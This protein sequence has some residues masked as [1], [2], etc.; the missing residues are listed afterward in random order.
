MRFCD[1]FIAYKIGLK[2][3]KNSI[4]FTKLPLY[5]KIAV[6]LTFAF[7]IL[8]LFM[9]IC[10]QVLIALITIIFALVSIAVFFII[11]STKNNLKTMLQDHYTPYSKKRMNMVLNLLENYKID[12]TNASTIDLL[13]GE[14]QNAQLQSDYL[15]LLKKPLKTLGTIIVPIVVYVAQKIGDTANQT[16]MLTM[17]VQV[18][19]LIILSFSLIFAVTPI[20]KD[21]AYRDFNKY[22]DFISDLTQI[23]I[24]YSKENPTP[25]N[26]IN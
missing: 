9:L 2:E 4:P 8:S 7:A 21:I 13:I 17:A 1:L 6:L 12:I 20:I 26:R 16:E 10:H 15:A 5:R 22:N 19:I 11:D 25:S 14:A 3:I 18:I 23:K 24:F